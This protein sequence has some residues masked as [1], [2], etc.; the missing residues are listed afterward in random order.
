M[1]TK[2][3]L[4]GGIGALAPFLFDLLVLD[5]SAMF[6][7]ISLPSVLGHLVRAAAFFGVGLFVVYLQDVPT[8][9]I[10]LQLGI[11]APALFMTMVNTGQLRSRNEALAEQSERIVQAAVDTTQASPVGPS[12]LDTVRVFLP[13][14]AR[15]DR[16]FLR[17]LAD[18]ALNKRVVTWDT[19][20]ARQE[21]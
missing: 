16:S 11:A 2:T 7:G 13:T 5:P 8:R 3:A 10:A 15:G 21:P 9:R 19:T 1:K 17:I 4:F 12:Q 6:Q 20:V 14:A 18:G